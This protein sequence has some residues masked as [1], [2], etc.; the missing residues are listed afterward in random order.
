[1]DEI[2]L[3]SFSSPAGELT[4]KQKKD[5]MEVLASLHAYRLIST[6]DMSESSALRKS[7]KELKRL[8][9]IYEVKESYPWHRFRITSAGRSALYRGA[10]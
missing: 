4:K 6:F 9:Y 10:R 7:I 1:M 5:P 2:H 8:K 3:C